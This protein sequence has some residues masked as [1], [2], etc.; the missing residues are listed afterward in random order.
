MPPTFKY[1]P[2]QQQAIDAINQNHSVLV[3]APTGSGKTAI[4][5]H[6]IDQSFRRGEQVV[7]TAPIKA[8]SNQK[9]REFNAQFPGQ[10]GILTGDVSIEPNAPLLI[11]TTEIYR[12]QLFENPEMHDK[13]A[14]VIFDEVHYLDDFERGTV[15]EEAIMFTRPTTRFLALSATAPNI[16]ELA[17]WVKSIHP[18]PVTVI[19]EDH[20]PVQ[21]QQLFQCQNEIY[22]DVSSLKRDGYHNLNIWASPHR[23]GRGGH[24]GPGGRNAHAGRGGQVRR[25]RSPQSWQRE[26]RAK[27][28]STRDLM[29]HLIQSDRMP[30]L[31]FAFGRKRVEELAEEHTGLSLL[32]AKEQAENLK[33]YDE[34]VAQFDLGQEKSAI[35]MGELVEHGIAYHHAGLLPTL[36]EV[37]ER[38]FT[39]KKI[40]LIFTTETFALGIN[41]PARTVVFDELR[42]FYGFGFDFL[43]N[44]DYFQMAG[45]AGR[46]GIDTVGFVYA[47]VNPHLI[48]FDVIERVMSGKMEPI[49]SQFNASYATLLNLYKKL[50]KKLIEVYPRSFHYFQSGQK[51]HKRAVALIERKIELLREMGYLNDEGLTPK[52]EFASWMYGYELML[53]ELWEAGDLDRLNP[54]E[55]CV[56]LMA[57]VYE[58]RKNDTMTS[59]PKNYKYLEKKCR[60]LHHHIYQREEHHHV[61]PFV[62][63]PYFNLSEATEAW[64]GGAQ[65]HE[66]FRHTDVDEGIIIRYFRMVIQLLRQ[67]KTDPGLPVQLKATINKTIPLIDRD[68]VDAERLL[69]AA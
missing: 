63:K 2:F 55:L 19:L 35:Q 1:D 58:P 4:A 57:L 36:K 69:R 11:M 40:Q 7:Y 23:G 53:S 47:R 44:R 66:L 60:E 14:W 31:Y 33:I 50:G 64:V 9:F 49:M 24:G 59:V 51:K 22:R 67:L 37:V 68:I 30:C 38:M 48:R 17:D 3:S 56:L 29:L 15:W 25:H 61:F 13:T 32:N 12:N 16:Q 27:P 20:R 41:M 46:R 39:M 5:E 43:T 62:K 18:H 54:M 8:I 26:L 52:G 28:N 6:A 21:L 10:V 34:L 45:R 65:F 42:K